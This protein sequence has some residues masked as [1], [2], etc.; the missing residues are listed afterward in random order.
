M[1]RVYRKL[2]ASEREALRD[3]LLRLSPEDRA[4]RFQAAQSEAAITAYCAAIDWRRGYVVGMFDAGVLRGVGELRLSDPPRP[5]RAEIAISVEAPWQNQGV[6]HELLHRLLVLARNRRI[7]RVQMICLIDN[8]RM[9]HIAAEVAKL[10]IEEGAAVAEI[11]VPEPSL[12][13]LYEEWM[14]DGL[15]LIDAWLEPSASGQTFSP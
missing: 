5:A 6:G 15:A 10:R 2:L 3:H 14:A 13:S 12:L 9:R 8:P 11:A 7:G 4:P 1:M